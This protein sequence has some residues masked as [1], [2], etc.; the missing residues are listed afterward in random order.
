MATAYTYLWY[1]SKRIV[2]VKLRR[3]K[4]KCAHQPQQQHPVRHCGKRK[5]VLGIVHLLVAIENTALSGP[6]YLS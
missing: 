4:T 3:Q 6:V 5:C 2:S 1:L